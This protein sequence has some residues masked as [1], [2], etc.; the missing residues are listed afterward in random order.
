[1]TI[2]QNFRAS[3]PWFASP[4]CV[5]SGAHN[6]RT[7]PGLAA[8]NA[9]GEIRPGVGL[10]SI[11]CQPASEAA[12][13]DGTNTITNGTGVE[14]GKPAQGPCASELLHAVGDFD[15]SSGGK[16]HFRTI[17][18]KLSWAV[19]WCK[20]GESIRVMPARLCHI[21]QQSSCARPAHSGPAVKRPSL[22]NECGVR[23]IALD[24]SAIL[25]G[26]NLTQ[27]Y[28]VRRDGGTGV[29]TIVR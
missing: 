11:S 1:M 13:S 3:I 22:S 18:K 12:K 21:S 4:A 8:G 2:G 23:S 17:H 14:N 19:H 7:A 20:D 28:G 6:A 27:G 25:H 10:K 26:T 5:R 15:L 24:D 29:C 9:G 16:K